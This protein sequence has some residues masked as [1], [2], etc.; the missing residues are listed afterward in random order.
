MRIPLFVLGLLATGAALAEPDTFGL[1]TGRSGPLRVDQPSTVINRYG[2]LTASAA[3]GTKDLTISNA[4]AFTVGELVLIHQLSGL[5]PAP[6][7]GEQRV[8]DLNSSPVGRFEYAR[9]AFVGDTLLRLT[10]PLR[11]SY[12]ASVSQVVSVP[13]YTD[14]QVL[15]GAS[16]KAAPWDGSTGG[17][18]ALLATGT[19]TNE[20]TISA[21]GAGFRGGEFINN[22][23]GE[24]CTSLDEAAGTGGSYKGEG[25]VAGRFGTAAGRGNLATGGGGGNCHNAGGGGGGHFGLGGKGG[26]SPGRTE[27]PDDVGGLGGAPV[28]YLPYER[29]LFGSGGGGGGGHVDV[30]TPGG[31]GGGMILIR[32]GDV[33]GTGRF[34]ATGISAAFVTSQGDD[35]AGGGGAGGAISLRVARALRCGLAQ[36]AGGAGGDTRHVS[37]ESGPG[38]GGGGGVVFLQAE[39]ITCPVSVVAGLP[40][41]STAA[42]GTY[43]AGPSVINSGA[44][45]GLEQTLLL[46]FRLPATPVLTQPAQGARGVVPRPRIEGTGEPGVIV[47]L[48]LDGVPY[49]RVVPDSAGSFSYNVPTDLPAGAHELRASAEALGVQSPL[50]APNGF[51]VGTPAGGDGGVPD[52]GA[53]VPDGGTFV[54]EPVLVAPL[55]GETVEPLALFAGTSQT[56]IAVSIDVDGSEVAYVKLD[57]QRR[58]RYTLT[59]EQKLAPGTHSVIVRAW[60]AVGRTGLSSPVT[61]FE[62]RAPEALEVGCGC[63]ASPGA[64]LGLAALLLSLGA[65]RLRRRE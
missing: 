45:Y 21:D 18:L 6:A 30:G 37:S 7:S 34:S 41:Q 3:A 22:L 20:G 44:S 47:Q 49:V 38:G 16:L 51:D 31:A 36:A 11:Y 58:F 12:A 24:G 46:P 9:V 65:A 48:Y 32:A 56:G 15:A 25:V 8:I 4:N 13:E 57:A 42:G 39:T 5:L 26:F 17:V 14:V 40:G 61:T 62:V 50:S 52:G 28:T 53:G 23:G 63:G 1:G 19:L 29:L 33:A 54:A 10:A 27:Q 59:A 55:E 64:G 35:G 2:Q 60:D 43:G